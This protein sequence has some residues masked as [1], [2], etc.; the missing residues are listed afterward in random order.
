MKTFP[1]LKTFAAISNVTQ[2]NLKPL[3]LHLQDRHR[4][5]GIYSNTFNGDYISGPIDSC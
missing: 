1:I 3:F 5:M 2:V 4:P